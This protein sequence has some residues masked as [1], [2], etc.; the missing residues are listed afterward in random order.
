MLTEE[1][2]G[3]SMAEDGAEVGLLWLE[4]EAIAVVV[5]VMRELA[6]CLAL[7]DGRAV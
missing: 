3:V 1:E 5:M 2:E 4:V 6:R 7:S